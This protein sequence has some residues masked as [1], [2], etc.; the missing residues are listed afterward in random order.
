MNQPTIQDFKVAINKDM[1][2]D[3]I[4]EAIDIERTRCNIRV[5]GTQIEY[6]N[7]GTLVVLKMADQENNIWQ[8]WN[9]YPGRTGLT[10]THTTP[11]TST[12]PESLW[13]DTFKSLRRLYGSE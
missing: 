13:S 11:L 6:C 1:S 12:M 2:S 8:H 7:E 9:Y 4:Y 3:D 5:G 10:L